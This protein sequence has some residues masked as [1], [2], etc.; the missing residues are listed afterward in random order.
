M[1]FEQNFLI[2]SGHPMTPQAERCHASVYS[3]R[4][5]PIWFAYPSYSANAQLSHRRRRNSGCSRSE[6]RVA[7]SGVSRPL[8]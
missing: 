7:C 3:T 2:F 1:C 6:G 5:G 8:L 4:R